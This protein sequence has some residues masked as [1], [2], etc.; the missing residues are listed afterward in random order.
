MPIRSH[1]RRSFTTTHR[2]GPGRRCA[3]RPFAADQ[4]NALSLR[5]RN[6]PAPF[7]LLAGVLGAAGLSWRERVATIRWFARQRHAGFRTDDERDGCGV[8]AG[9]AAARAGR[10]LDAAVPRCAEHAAAARIRAGVPERAPRIVG[11]RDRRDGDAGSEQRARRGDSRAC[12]AMAGRARTF[13]PNVVADADRGHRRRRTRHRFERHVSRGRGDRRGG[14]ASARRRVRTG[15][16][17]ARRPH[18]GRGA[19]RAAIRVGTD[20]DRLS[21]LRRGRCGAGRTRT[22]RRQPRPMVVR[23]RATSS[24]ARRLRRRLPTCAPCYPS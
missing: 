1:C 17:R 14:T 23:S 13:R 18:R 8:A 12:G 24:R 20:H 19:R 15:L 4:A 10:P 22:A 16:A 2:P 7:G 21:R 6:L 11:R 5:A 9:F 3:I